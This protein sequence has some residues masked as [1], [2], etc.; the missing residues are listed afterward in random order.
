MNIL[1][2]LFFFEFI[3]LRHIPQSRAAGSEVG[4]CHLP[5]SVFPDFSIKPIGNVRVHPYFPIAPPKLALPFWF[6]LFLQVISIFKGSYAFLPHSS[7]L[8]DLAKLCCSNK[9]TPNLRLNVQNAFLAHCVCPL[10]GVGV[11]LHT[12]T[13]GPGW[14]RSLCCPV[15]AYDASSGGRQKGEGGGLCRAFHS[16]VA[17]LSGWNISEHSCLCP[18][19]PPHLLSCLLTYDNFCVQ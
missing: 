7:L 4:N 19:V 13:L 16:C 17:W 2:K 6:F 3:W 12:V 1:S 18:S 14:L 9:Q 10:W 11:Q 5:C 15:A 8:L